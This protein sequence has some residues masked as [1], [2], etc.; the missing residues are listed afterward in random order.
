MIMV[1]STLYIF[2]C[3]EPADIQIE[4]FIIQ[5]LQESGSHVGTVDIWGL[6][7]KRW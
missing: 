4:L 6:S 5:W 1:S 2:K 3:E 7:A